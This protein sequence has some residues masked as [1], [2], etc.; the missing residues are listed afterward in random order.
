[1]ARR[2]F[3]IPMFWKFLVGCLTL[4][5]L[6]IAGAYLVVR[7]ERKM[8]DRGEYLEKHF[9]RYPSRFAK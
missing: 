8:K 3:R 5:G 2:P 7:S 6:L 1:M 4:A 9:K